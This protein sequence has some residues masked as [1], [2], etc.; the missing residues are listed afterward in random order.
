MSQQGYIGR[1]PGDGRTIVNRQTSHVTTGVQTSFTMTVG[2]EVGYLDV[3]LNGIKQ[4][5]TLDYT[6]ADGSTINFSPSFAPMNG[7]VLEFVAFETLNISNIK[8]ARRNFSVGQ[9]LDVSGKVTIGSSLTVA[10]D[11]VVN[12][13]FTTIN[14]EILDVEDKTV[15]IASTSSPSNTTADGAGIVIYGGSDGDKSLTWNSTKSNFVLVGGGVSIGTGVTIS[16]PANNVLAFSVNSAEKARFNNFGAFTVGYEGEAWH[17]STYVGVL[18]AGSGAWIGQTPGASARAEWVNNAYYDSVNTRWEYIAADEANRIVLENGEL[19]L[20]SADAGSADGAITWNEKLK[21]TV[22]GD[23]KIGAPTGIGITISSSGNVDSI[24]IVTCASLSSAGAISGTTGTFSGDVSIADKIVHTGDTNTAIRFTNSDQ[25]QFETAGVERLEIQQTEA[26]F[27]DGGADFNLRVEGDTDV[28]LLKVDA[29]T[30]K[31]GIGVASPSA[32]LEVLNDV[33]VKGS[34]GDGSVGIQIRSGGSALSNQHQIRTGG[35]SGDQL[36]IE[37]L[38]ASSAI[39]SKVAGSERLRIG[40]AGQIGIAG[41]NYGTSGQALISGGSSGSVSW[42][43]VNTD[44]VSDTSPQLGGDLDTNGHE[45]SL[46]D[47][48]KI[49]FGAG[50]DLQIYSNGI[51]GYI[52][53]V[54]TGTGADLILRSKTFIVRNLSDETMI[55]GNQ[56]GSV[57]LYHD[58]VNTMYTENGGIAV[59]DNDTTSYIKMVT[60]GGD[61]GYLHGLNNSEMSLLDRE[62]HYFI[63]GTKDGAT[64]LYYDNAIKISTLSNGVQITGQEFISEGTILLE[65]SGAHHHRILSND[66]GNDLAFQQSSDTG[67]NTNFTTY[68]RI[69]DGGNISLPVDNQQLRLG[70]SGDL[71]LMHENDH[72]YVQAYNVGNMYMGTI[73]NADVIIRQNSQNRYQFAAGGFNPM[74]DN[75]YDLGN[76]SARWRNLYTGDINLSNKGSQND[77][78]GTW[79][80]Y[81]IQEGESDLF[82][83]N[84]RSGKKFK[85]MLQEVS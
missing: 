80:D 68:L 78:D 19:K 74:T 27:N 45:I 25:I 4:T 70:A 26:V 49:N 22:G 51:A 33:Y 28:N 65:K 20:Q 53:H 24:G 10:S 15:G 12:G 16:T 3:Y 84:K 17:E 43:T 52:D 57:N 85:F 72:S 75:V 61:A 7:D 47:N 30:D 42:G 36:F 63:R 9:D 38:G 41:A 14:T 59:S 2:Y 18:Q 71:I 46:D 40:P 5:E 8:S 79:G 6:A 62:G 21:M 67:A 69:N 81:T 1:N 54:T 83:I 73:H 56:N 32:K 50:N 64:D 82:L 34:S 11:L 60:T 29:G 13:T 31:I 77:V 37:A 23:F 58:N 66:S 44:L 48:H 76:S 35:G 39:V 55:V